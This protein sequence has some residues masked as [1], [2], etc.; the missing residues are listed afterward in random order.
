MKI[1]FE[2]HEYPLALVSANVRKPFYTEIV[3]TQKATIPYIGYFFN[4]T[5][6]DSVFILPKV[7]IINHKAFGKYAPEA[8]I[9]TT[10]P[11]NPLSAQNDSELIYELS[12]WIYRAI[13]HY[14]N[15]HASSQIGVTEHLQ[16]VIS[17][18]GSNQPSF[19]DII[20][21]LLRFHKSH[22]QL[23]T[24]ISIINNSGNNK[25]H[26]AKTINK[27]QPI[28]QDK[29][30]IYTAFQNR[31]KSVNYDEE[32]I[33][34]FYSVLNYL[35]ETYHF[36]L[37]RAI[38]Y[39]LL[40]SR[41]IAA[42][43]T[44][45]KGTRLLR[46]IRKK[47]FTDELVQLWKLLYLFFDRA[48]RVA[49]NGYH[50]EVLLVRHFNL[51]FEDMIDHL[52]G[53][54]QRTLPAALKEQRDGKLVDHIFKAPSLFDGDIYF[55]G[56]SKYYKDDHFLGAQSIYKQFTYA[57]NVIQYNID[58][59]NECGEQR[60][61]ALGSLRYRDELTEGYNITPNFFIRGSVSENPYSF[62]ESQIEKGAQ[63]K[64]LP[65]NIHFHDRLFDRDTLLLQ[66]YNIN[67][68]FVLATYVAGEVDSNLK[69]K[70]RSQFRRDTLALYNAR[71]HFY[72]VTPTFP[73]EDFVEKHFHR[74]HGKMYRANDHDDFL[75]F[76][77]EKASADTSEL[78][79]IIQQDAVV[80]C[81]LL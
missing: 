48:E 79:T 28:M 53:D 42:M 70:I 10:A 21:Q 50:E 40:S 24:H 39:P 69:N 18:K 41:K 54:D 3:A 16:N 63:D 58:L 23:L 55:I 80:E 49:H 6:K 31:N 64:L 47:Y 75:W 27:T 33:V 45:Q 2:E 36:G 9:D 11:N 65:S 5:I 29:T 35:Q 72:K 78:L 73:I 37:Q 8:I 13:E 22:R 20:L 57:K 32:L 60:R 44:S 15:R 26:W 43:I 77:F 67:F 19:L 34:L 38:Q 1:Y 62:S 4:P 68:L 30:P 71:Y 56:D 74:F 12:T 52:I 59:F 61:S 81:C 25:I 46:S 51:V 7:F 17:N 14:F 66:T 76:A